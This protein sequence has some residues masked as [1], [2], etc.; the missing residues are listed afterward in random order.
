MRMHT[1]R[2]WLV[3]EVQGRAVADDICTCTVQICSA[4]SVNFLIYRQQSKPMTAH[5]ACAISPLLLPYRPGA[6]CH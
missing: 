4:A 2:G 6:I 5:R 1:L 3:D